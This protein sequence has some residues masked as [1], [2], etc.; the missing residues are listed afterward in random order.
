MQNRKPLSQ[1]SRFN[2]PA[3]NVYTPLDSAAEVTS[4]QL[5]DLVQFSG[6]I[7]SVDTNRSHTWPVC[8]LCLSDD[9]KL[10]GA[11]QLENDECCSANTKLSSKCSIFQCGQCG[12][13]AVETLHSCELE[14]LVALVTVKDVTLAR[15][16]VLLIPPNSSLNVTKLS[17]PKSVFKH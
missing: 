12:S 15:P 16:H 17:N 8:A 1:P 14:V 3:S 7:V 13:Q 11:Q 2:M 9:L 4:L 10:T 6:T 5:H